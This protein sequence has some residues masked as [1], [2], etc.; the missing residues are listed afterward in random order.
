MKEREVRLYGRTAIKAYKLAVD[1]QM[2]ILDKGQ[3]LVI[4]R[5]TRAINRVARRTTKKDRPD[6]GGAAQK[7]GKAQPASQAAT[8]APASAGGARS[9]AGS[10]I[11]ELR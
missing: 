4:D 3:D 11:M 10:S 5:L 7:R 8:S 9:A 1:E 2:H 6:G